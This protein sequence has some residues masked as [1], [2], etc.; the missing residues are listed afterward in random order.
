MLPQNGE[1][2]HQFICFISENLN[3]VYISSLYIIIRSCKYIINDNRV[4]IYLD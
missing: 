3:T 2:V 1:E 4:W